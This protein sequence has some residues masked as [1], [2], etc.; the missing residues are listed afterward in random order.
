MAF[1]A[2]PSPEELFKTF[3]T[4]VNNPKKTM[5][6]TKKPSV[7]AKGIY[8][9]MKESNG[10]EVIEVSFNAD[11]F[12]EFLKEHRDVKGYVK[13]NAWPKAVADNFGSHNLVLNSWR[14]TNYGN[15]APKTYERPEKD[16]DLP[17]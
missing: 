3:I 10:L 17:F 1:V 4:F 2:E 7:Y 9:H 14:P 6:Q 13:I 11:A 16:P 12:I 5:S 8:F 15:N